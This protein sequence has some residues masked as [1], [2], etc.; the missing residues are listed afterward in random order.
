MADEL[1]RRQV[2]AALAAAAFPAPGAT[3]APEAA[4]AADRLAKARREIRE[5]VAKME[6]FDLP[7]ATEPAFIFKP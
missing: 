5:T 7:F 3:A 4:S 2:A 1:T 6:K